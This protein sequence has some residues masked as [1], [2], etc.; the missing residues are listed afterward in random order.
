MHPKIVVSLYKPHVGKEKELEDR[1]LHHVEALIELGVVSYRPRLV[2]KSTNGTYIELLER[3]EPKNEKSFQS[4]RKFKEFMADVCEIKTL[5]D[6]PEAH[7]QFADFEEVV[8]LSETYSPKGAV[9]IQHV[10][11]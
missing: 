4:L 2:F 9:P 11:F 8:F 10:K 3:T 1:I 6:I 5:A 7:K